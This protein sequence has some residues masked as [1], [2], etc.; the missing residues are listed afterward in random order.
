MMKGCL[1]AQILPHDEV[2]SQ[3]MSIMPVSFRVESSGACCATYCCHS[4]LLVTLSLSI[5]IAGR[6]CLR[7]TLGES[8]HCMALLCTDVFMPQ[9]V[10]RPDPQRGVCCVLT[11]LAPGKQGCSL[12][13]SLDHGNPCLVAYIAQVKS[14]LKQTESAAVHMEWQCMAFLAPKPCGLACQ[15]STH[16]QMS[17]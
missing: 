6:M 17:Y 16:M 10:R 7:L 4:L 9:V 8:S 1:D 13:G 3:D 14:S 12:L 11:A 5:R 2:I 15:K